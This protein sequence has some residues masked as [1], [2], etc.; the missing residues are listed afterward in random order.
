[1]AISAYRFSAYRQCAPVAALA[2]CVLL[3]GSASA[4]QQE[5]LRYFSIA[6]VTPLVDYCRQYA[7]ERTSDVQRGF[8][9]YVQRL[10]DALKGRRPSVGIPDALTPQLTAEAQ[11]AG[12]RLVQSIRHVEPGAYCAWLAS[13]LQLTT[14]EM[15]VEGLD[16]F[17]RQAEA[18]RS[19]PMSAPK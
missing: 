12:A 18:Q 11:A 1:M 15:M 13:R 8:D 3:A 19:G 10:D 4:T 7:P 16:Q 5:V 9:N 14:R 2:C 17:D 6:T